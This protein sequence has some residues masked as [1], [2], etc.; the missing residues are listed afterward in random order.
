MLT[1]SFIKSDFEG[2]DYR[3]CN[4][5]PIA[6]AA[7]RTLGINNISVGG[8]YIRISNFGEK[9][10]MYDFIAPYPNG[11]NIREWKE[12]YD[13]NEFAELV[14]KLLNIDCDLVPTNADVEIKETASKPIITATAE[15]N[16]FGETPFIPQN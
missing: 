9:G 7:K 1:L 12:Y 15:A 11:R 5:C 13:N 2:N 8:D 10:K 16:A 14:P 6:R 4:D 3:E